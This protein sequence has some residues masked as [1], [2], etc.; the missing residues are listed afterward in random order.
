MVESL[1][2][3]RLFHGACR[4]DVASILRDG[5]RA[6]PTQPKGGQVRHGVYLTD[7]YVLATDY[8]FLACDRANQPNDE[9]VVLE[10]D[11]RALELSR[12][13][14]DDYDLQ[15][16][17]QGGEIKNSEPID[18]R[19]RHLSHWSEAD[20]QLSLAVT[21]QVFYAGSIAPSAIKEV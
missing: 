6:A 19:L 12:L 10:I 1:G 7:D 20:W 2:I 18:A 15:D 14:P 5:L 3:P 16:A 21:H 11:T 9:I 17:I 8:G 4:R 13:Q